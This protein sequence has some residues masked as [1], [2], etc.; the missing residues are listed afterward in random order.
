MYY[1]GHATRRLLLLGTS[2]RIEAMADDTSKI[3]DDYIAG[4]SGWRGTKL[5]HYRQLI[6][7]TAPDMTEGWKWDVPVYTGRKM[8]CAMSAFKD[9]IKINFFKGAQLGDPDG[10]FN[11]GLDSKSHRSINLFEA[12]TVDDQAFRKLLLSAVELDG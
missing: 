3:I 12:E 7:E 8:V 5:A 2:R 4:L 10:L 9:H 11:G 1:I 6:R